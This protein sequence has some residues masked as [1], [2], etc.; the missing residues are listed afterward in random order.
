MCQLYID[1]PAEDSKLLIEDGKPV[2][3]DGKPV[4]VPLTEEELKQRDDLLATEAAD[5]A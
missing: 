2:M 5:D 1:H 3:R 4:F